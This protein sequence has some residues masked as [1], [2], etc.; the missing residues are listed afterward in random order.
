MIHQ[1]KAAAVTVS[2]EE[3][4]LHGVLLNS[5]MASPASPVGKNHPST[6]GTSTLTS[7][8]LDATTLAGVVSATVLQNSADVVC[9]VAATASHPVAI[10][11]I[12]GKHG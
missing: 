11:I 8:A 7:D 3:M 2:V 9:A 4:V 10:P 6:P 12:A 1:Q 5:R